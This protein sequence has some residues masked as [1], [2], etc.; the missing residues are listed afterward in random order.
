MSSLIA[1]SK[2]VD[3]ELWEF[4]DEPLHRSLSKKIKYMNII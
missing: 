3:G 4:N 2:A 1:Y